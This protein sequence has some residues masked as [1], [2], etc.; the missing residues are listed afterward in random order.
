[1]LVRAINKL[2]LF[3]DPELIHHISMK[4]LTLSPVKSVY[5]RICYG[6]NIKWD[7]HIGLAAGFDKDGIYLNTLSDIGFGAIEVGTVT[8][9]PQDGNPRP[10][11]QK[12]PKTNSI[13][14]WMGFPSSGMEQVYENLKKYTK[15]TPLGINIGKN[16]A[17]P[18]SEAVQDYIKV[19]LKL[20][21]FASYFVINISSPNTPGLRDLQNK[22]FVADILNEFK[23]NKLKSPF[24]KVSPDIHLRDLEEIVSVIKSHS[25]AGIV[26]TN[27]TSQH[28][29][30]KGGVSGYDLKSKS[31][32]ITKFVSSLNTDQSF[33][34]IA[35]GG[36]ESI[37]DIEK[38]KA[39]GINH[40][41]IFSSF[42]YQGPKIVKKLLELY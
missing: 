39:L 36:I 16:K 17:T 42:V 10:R 11:I 26:T 9:L 1:M 40:F 4:A 15:A 27:T 19:A 8:P 18:N 24:I 21:E 22:G 25:G 3:I 20:K 31:Y 2:S 6:K 32:K 28:S 12:L 23:R 7:N 33:D 14:N 38:Y 35:C 30:D 34:I 13:R 29:Y 41:Q 37:G 5:K